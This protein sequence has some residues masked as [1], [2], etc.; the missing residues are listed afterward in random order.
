MK[1]LA[2]PPPNKAKSAN[3]HL[4]GTIDLAY[5]YSNNAKQCAMHR[6]TLSKSNLTIRQ[7]PVP[8]LDSSAWR[9]FRGLPTGMGANPTTH[10]AKIA[11]VK[12]KLHDCYVKL[13]DPATPALLCESIGWTLA[14]ASEVPTAQFSAI[15]FVPLDE[16][17]KSVHLPDWTNGHAYCP[18]WCSEIVAGKSVR[19]VHKWSFWLAR[20]NCLKSKDVR[21][22][23]ALDVWADNRDRNY[24]N[25]IRSSAGGYI[26]IDHET[27]LHDLLWLPVGIAYA[28]RSLHDEAKLHLSENDLKQFNVEMAT[29]SKKHWAGLT[30]I[31][32]PLK[33]LIDKM[34][35]RDAPIL[36]ETVFNYLCQRAQTGW[37][38]NQIGVIA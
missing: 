21:S 32:V 2:S 27:L 20:K 33:N 28:R 31:E 11:D 29:A 30:Q 18:A 4:T 17:R 14:Q 12:G 35:P 8:I 3:Q 16:L 7:M 5:P 23:A 6:F 19:Q 26:A 25:V 38:A 22:I 34:Y 36:G 37:L 9:E 15:A 10:L 1:N 13:L 24:G